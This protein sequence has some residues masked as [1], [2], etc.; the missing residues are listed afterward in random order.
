MSNSSQKK[1]ENFIVGT[2]HIG[3]IFLQVLHKH[4]EQ[5]HV[6]AKYQCWKKKP[7]GL[8]QQTVAYKINITTCQNKI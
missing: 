5:E 6:L 1:N 8:S 3:T 2:C 4:F 7:R